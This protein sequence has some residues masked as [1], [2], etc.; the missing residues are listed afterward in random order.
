LI[1]FKSGSSGI[2]LNVGR[3]KKNSES[4]LEELG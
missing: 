1:F 2:A 4:K 3:I